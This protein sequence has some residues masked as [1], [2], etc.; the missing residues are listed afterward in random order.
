M[1]NIEK[2]QKITDEYGQLHEEGCDL[3]SEDGSFDGCDCVMKALSEEVAE[4]L[5]QQLTELRGKIEGMK[6]ETTETKRIRLNLGQGNYSSLED[7]A[8]I[9]VRKKEFENDENWREAFG[10]NKALSDIVIFIYSMK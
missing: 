3:N 4:L 8:D 10:Y 5:T 7:G 6:I 2:V 9:L 1:T